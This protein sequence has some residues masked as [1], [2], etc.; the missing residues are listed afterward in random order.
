MD[1]DYLFFLQG[2]RD[3]TGGIFDEFFNAVSKIAVDIMPI[4]PFLVYW[5][6]DKSWGYRF[7][8]TLWCGEVINGIVKLTVCAYRPWIRDSRIVPAGDS[9]VAAT[10]YS[11][12]SGHTMCATSMYGTT[13]V[14]QHKK[15]KWLAIGCGVMILITG[16]S[17]NF[18]GVHTPQDVIV[19][20]T[21]T[22]VIVL[23]AGFVQK[24]VNGNSDLADKLTICGIVLAVGAI[25]YVQLKSY[26]MDYVDG[27]LLVDPEKMKKDLFKG[28]G[29]LI[30]L[31]IGSFIERHYIK[32][33]IPKGS[34]TLPVMACV[35]TAL[36]FIWDQFLEGI[37]FK[38]WFGNNWGGLISA[39]I[40][41]ILAVDVYPLAIMKSA[42]KTSDEPASAEVPVSE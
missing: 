28:V 5:A 24:K 2:I 21:E 7:L 6:V 18:L 32:Y 31:M 23:I 39:F 27:A 37:T 4:L 38:V 15:R 19:G 17:R 10:G 1:M 13:A 26:P 20:F 41:V 36:I 3:T 9:K 8:G 14:W 40:M 34:D 16:F 42:K 11:F 12:P 30:G 33:T 29:G 35:G 25:I 22:A